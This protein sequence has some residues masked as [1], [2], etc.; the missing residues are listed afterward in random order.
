MIF[1]DTNI[2]CYF[3]DKSSK[4]NKQASQ[5]IEKALKKEEIL[6]NTAII[7]EISHFLVKNLGP[8]NGKKKIEV[9]LEF[10]LQIDNFDYSAAKTAISMLCEYSHGG[11]GGRDATILATMKKSGCKKLVTHDNCFKNIEWL[12]V[13]DPVN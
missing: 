2:W 6:I 3:F 1:V 9:F 5:Y 13:I 10:P 7:M 4:E 11:I 8:V 12:D